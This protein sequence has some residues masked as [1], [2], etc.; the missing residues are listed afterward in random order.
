MGVTKPTAPRSTP[1]PVKARVS[2]TKGRLSKRTAFVRDI[3]KEVTGLVIPGV[4][5][6]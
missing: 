5:P 1:R 2:R 3:V 4:R 6:R